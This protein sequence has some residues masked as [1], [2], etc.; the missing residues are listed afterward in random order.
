[1]GKIMSYKKLQS[2]P[3]LKLDFLNIFSGLAILAVVLM[4]SHGPFIAGKDV[5][6]MNL[7]HF[8]ITIFVTSAV[9]CFILIA[10]FK[11]EYNYKISTLSDYF[12]FIKHRFKKIF[13]PFIAVSFFVFT[14]TYFYPM[15]V[16]KHE[17]FLFIK[18]L[19]LNFVGIGTEPFQ[20]WFVPMFMFVIGLY[21][22]ITYLIRNSYLRFIVLLLCWFYF[23]NNSINFLAYFEFFIYFEIGIIFC[24]N[25]SKICKNKYLIYSSLLILLGLIIVQ[26]LIETKE[27][28]QAATSG[29]RLIQPICYFYLAH[30]I[31]KFK[32][33]TKVFSFLGK[34]SWPIFLFH[35]PYFMTYSFLFFHQTLRS[36]WYITMILCAIISIVLSVLFYEKVIQ[37]TFLRKLFS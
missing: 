19:L 37:K 3:K 33:S 8:L 5:P 27:M 31:L 25:Y 18:K 6:Q 13:I 21:P 28:L 1:M 12:E 9:P 29:I 16:Q 32:L 36:S 34:Y 30:Y 11:Q 20:L 23:Q 7:A 17:I 26:R 15:I 2:E 24:K 22:L 10:G 35:Q 14:V 4:H